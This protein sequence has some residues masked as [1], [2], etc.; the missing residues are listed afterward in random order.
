MGLVFLQFTFAV[1]KK[2]VLHA[3]NYFGGESTTSW[4]ETFTHKIWQ[5]CSN[6]VSGPDLHAAHESCHVATGDGSS[7]VFVCFVVQDKYGEFGSAGL[8]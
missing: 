4:L 2:A 8:S 1:V 3:T 5:Q 7:Y 6:P